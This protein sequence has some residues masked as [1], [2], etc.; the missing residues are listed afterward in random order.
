MRK[1]AVHSPRQIILVTLPFRDLSRYCFA[2]SQSIVRVPHL[3]LSLISNKSFSRRKA[4]QSDS[5]LNGSPRVNYIR[6]RIVSPPPLYI[7]SSVVNALCKNLL[8]TSR[9]ILKKKKN[10][11]GRSHFTKEILLNSSVSC[12]GI[13]SDQR[14]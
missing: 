2:S 4:V 7:C 12:P 5:S 10:I 13:V 8:Q 3:F 11:E 14:G 6:P 1:P 9:K